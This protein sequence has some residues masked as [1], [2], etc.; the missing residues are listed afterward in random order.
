MGPWTNQ[1]YVC[2]WL[3]DDES[4]RETLAKRFQRQGMAVTTASAAA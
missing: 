3:N 2:S 4:L 1:N